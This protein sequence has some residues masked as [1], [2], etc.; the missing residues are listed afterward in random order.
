MNATGSSRRKL[1]NLVIDGRALAR[2]SLPF[3]TMGLLSI[4]IVFAI[5]RQVLNALEGTEL[6]GLEN[7]GA[8]N[9]LHELQSRVTMLGYFAVLLLTFVCFALWVAVSHRIFGPVVAMRRHVRS[10]IAGEYTSRINLRANDELRDL[11]EDLN[12]LAQTLD[13]SGARGN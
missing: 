9:A 7:L 1:T 11:G 13:R 2:L 8:V 3:F 10:L 6:H 4:G 12:E 5:R